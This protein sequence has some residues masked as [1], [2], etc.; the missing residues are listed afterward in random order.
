MQPDCDRVEL[1]DGVTEKIL[2]LCHSRV[3]L[4]ETLGQ[5]VDKKAERVVNRLETL[6]LLIH[7]IHTGTNDLC[8]QCRG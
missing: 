8:N 2:V 3:A 4:D 6:Q 7:Y 1:S 5:V